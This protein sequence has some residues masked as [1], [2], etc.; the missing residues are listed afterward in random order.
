MRGQSWCP[1]LLELGEV[2]VLLKGLL[3]EWHGEYHKEHLGDVGALRSGVVLHSDQHNEQHEEQLGEV[4][5]PLQVWLLPLVVLVLRS[6]WE[7]SSFRPRLGW[8]RAQ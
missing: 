3:K 7:G 6:S 4:G 5:R 8:G 2:L 1:P